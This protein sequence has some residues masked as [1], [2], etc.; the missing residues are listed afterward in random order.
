L[1]INRML[2]THEYSSK[3]FLGFLISSWSGFT[4]MEIAVSS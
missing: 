2:F 3:S 1:F 4:L